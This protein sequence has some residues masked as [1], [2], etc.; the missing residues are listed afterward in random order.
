MELTRKELIEKITALGLSESFLER[1]TTEELRDAYLSFDGPY[2]Y[3][4]GLDS[5]R[6][7]N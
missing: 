3:L 1:F 5:A 4:T 6:R 2:K 7:N